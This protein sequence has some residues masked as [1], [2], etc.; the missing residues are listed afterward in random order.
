MGEVDV[1]GRVRYFG[2]KVAIV[3]V[4]DRRTNRVSA[5]VVQNIERHILHDFIRERI[6]ICL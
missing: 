5:E 6:S 4:K 3:G 2:S 1:D